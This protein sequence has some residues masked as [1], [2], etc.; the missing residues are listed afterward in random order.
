[1][2]QSASLAEQLAPTHTHAQ[3]AVSTVVPMA[4][5]KDNHLRFPSRLIFSRSPLKGQSAA[6]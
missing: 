2:G 1:M 6:V 4:D 3:I 5:N